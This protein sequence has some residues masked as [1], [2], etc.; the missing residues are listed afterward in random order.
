MNTF[1]DMVEVIIYKNKKQVFHQK[2]KTKK[3]TRKTNGL[4]ATKSRPKLILV[5]IVNLVD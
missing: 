1:V 3:K 5:T 2:K 4:Y